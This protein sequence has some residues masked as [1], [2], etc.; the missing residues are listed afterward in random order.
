M[1]RAA[2][3]RHLPVAVGFSAVA[4]FAASPALAGAEHVRSEGPM[5]VYSAAVPTGATAEAKAVYNSAGDTIVTLHV[6][7]LKPRTEYGAHAHVNVCGLDGAAAGA[8]FQN[9]VDPVSPSVDPAY[10]NSSNEIWLDLT[11]DAAGNGVAHAKV[12]WQF[13]PDRRARSVILHEQHTSELPGSAGTAGARL[14]CLD[15]AF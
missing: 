9:V 10:A 3:T 5:T 6:R 4:L 2:L 7:G 13:S 15:V 1:R 12:S 11:T 8:H 14:A